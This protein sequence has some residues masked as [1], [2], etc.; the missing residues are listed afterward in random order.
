MILQV[1]TTA[2]F[3]KT[4]QERRVIEYGYNAINRL[5]DYPEALATLKYNHGI[6]DFEHIQRLANGLRHGGEVEMRDIR[7]NVAILRT[8]ESVLEL[9]KM[10]DYG[11]PDQ[12]RVILEARDQQIA[13]VQEALRTIR[14]AERELARFTPAGCDEYIVEI[15]D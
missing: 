1:K 2:Q 14:F 3:E 15:E 13:G 9:D 7:R 11:T 8:L 6:E 5:R 10:L 4:A 12:T